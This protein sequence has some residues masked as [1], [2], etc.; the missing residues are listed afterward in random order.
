MLILQA[1]I[2][3]HRRRQRLFQI[4][5]LKPLIIQLCQ[6]VVALSQLFCL[7]KP[8][9]TYFPHFYFIMKSFGGQG[10]KSN[11]NRL[12]PDRFPTVCYR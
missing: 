2:R 11:L 10:E 7:Q 1:L 4:H 12:I 3:H 8:K 6:R 9:R 5:L